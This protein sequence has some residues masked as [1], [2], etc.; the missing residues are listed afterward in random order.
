MITI[1]QDKVSC[2]SPEL[3][4]KEMTLAKFAAK[5]FPQRIDTGQVI[6][7]DGVKAI[8]PNGGLRIFVHQT[9]PRVHAMKWLD[10]TKP[11]KAFKVV[12][13]SLPYVI[14][15]AGFSQEGLQ[16]KNE[17][18]FSNSPIRSLHDKLCYPALLN[19]SKHTKYGNHGQDGIPLSWICTQYLDFGKAHQGQDRNEKVRN[20]LKVLLHCHFETGFNRSSERNEGSSWF[21]ETSAVRAEIA[22]VEKWEAASKKDPLFGLKV[23]WLPTDKTVMEIATRHN[24]HYLCKA[25]GG[26]TQESLERILFS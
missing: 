9:S 14:I 8:I 24:G 26:V 12:S 25:N 7:P 5:A 16:N 23:D 22:T 2:T 11:S 21:K 17:C 20:G 15:F 13:L 3:V 18:F 4:K 1:D 10:E 19:C 6:L